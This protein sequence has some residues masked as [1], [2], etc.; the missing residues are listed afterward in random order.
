MII[1]QWHVLPGSVTLRCYWLR[2]AN[3]ILYIHE[4]LCSSLVEVK[5]TVADLIILELQE[6]YKV[7][8]SSFKIRI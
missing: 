5:V 7:V 8:N 6:N 3:S 1:V 2:S 4:Y